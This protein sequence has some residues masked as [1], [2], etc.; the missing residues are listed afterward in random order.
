MINAD[1]FRDYGGTIEMPEKLTLQTGQETEISVTLQPSFFSRIPV[2]LTV[3]N[4][5][6]PG[7]TP[8]SPSTR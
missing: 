6:S 8:A 3:G 5:N 1:L 2:T 4:P 7:T